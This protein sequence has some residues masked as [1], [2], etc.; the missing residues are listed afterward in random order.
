MHSNDHDTDITGTV[1]FISC[2]YGSYRMRFDKCIEG[3]G[4]YLKH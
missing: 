1:Y 4:E 3:R 2:I